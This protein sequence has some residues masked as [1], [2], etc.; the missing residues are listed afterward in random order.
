MSSNKIITIEGN[1]GS[2][3]TT[4][5]KHLQE[6]YKN[7]KNIVFLREPVD[8]WASIKD[9]NGITM[10]QKFYEDQEKYSFSFQMMA[11]ISRLAL[12]KDAIFLNPIAIIITERSLYTDKFVFAKMLYDMKKIEDVNY[13]IYC[14]WF[15]TFADECPIHQC[16]YVKTNPDICDERIIKRSRVGEAGIPLSY[17]QNCDEY[18]NSMMINIMQMFKRKMDDIIILDGNIDI[19]SK[20][21]KLNDWLDK[22]EEFIFYKQ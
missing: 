11:Y 20:P 10:L 2:G 5:L 12:L 21:D 17:L 14:K 3:K 7:N 6:K 8:D 13:Q 4:L 22:I 15:D 18:H 19:Y 9:S 1:I 16:I